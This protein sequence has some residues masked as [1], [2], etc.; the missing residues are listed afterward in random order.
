MDL[1]S[2][3]VPVYNVEKYLNKCVDSLINQTYPNIEII[4]IDDGS[5]DTSGKKCDEFADSDSRIKV[6]HK[7]N[8]GLSDARNAGIEIASG[9]YIMFVDSDDYVMPE[10]VELLYRSL[11]N[12]NE[13]VICNF[14]YVN[15]NGEVIVSKE[16]ML[17]KNEVWSKED[18]WKHYYS[19]QIVTCVVA[20]NKLY[21]KDWFACIR[22]E[23][24]KYNEDEFILKGIIDQVSVIRCISPKLYFYTQ[25]NNSIM[26]NFNLKRL[27]AVEAYL[28][29]GSEFLCE[30]QVSFAENS[31]TLALELLVEGYLKLDLGETEVKKRFND[32]KN[33]LKKVYIK[34][35]KENLTF[36]F[37]FNTLIFLINIRLYIFLHN[38]F[39]Q[40]VYGKE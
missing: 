32:L 3:V 24:G 40:K 15:E 37:R 34:M 16:N 35:Q 4:L 14:E 31:I 38:K 19:D 27:D 2:I 10:M 23:A 30:N 5:E 1:I 18:F 6:I 22:Y 36:H 39:G 28:K 11:R 7:K 25:R 33:H 9:K 21:K 12:K 29:R 8:G 17:L 13:L 26:G 20:W